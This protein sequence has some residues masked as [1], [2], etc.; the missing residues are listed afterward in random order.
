[1]K[2]CQMD[3]ISKQKSRFWA[4]HAFFYVEEGFDQSMPCVV[5]S[6]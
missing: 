5:D 3:M 2:N 6:L 1:M 4:K